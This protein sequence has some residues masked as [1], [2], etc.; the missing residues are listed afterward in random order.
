MLG[1]PN[2]A[3]LSDAAVAGTRR[4]ASN[5]QVLAICATE[6]HRT[7]SSS[8]G[9]FGRRRVV[10]E[11]LRGV[12]LDVPQ[13][14]LFGLLGPN[15]AG[16][17]TLIKILSTVLL[18]T[19]GSVRVFDHDITRDTGSVRRI[20]GLVFGGDRGVYGTL[21]GRDTLRFWADLY[22]LEPAY[23]RRR[24]EEVLQ[25]VGLAGRAEERVET[26]S[27][28]MKQR[29]HL[30]RG[31]LH[32][33]DLLLLDEPTIGLDPVAALQVREIVRDL[34]RQGMTILLTTHYM[35]EAESLCGRVAFI[36]E[37]QIVSVGSPKALTQ[38]ADAKVVLELTVTH[39]AAEALRGVLVDREITV[40]ESPPSSPLVTLHISA[41]R[42][43]LSELLGIVAAYQPVT[44]RTVEPSLED[45]YLRLLGDRGMRI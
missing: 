5:T 39:L 2:P 14:E 8:A 31:I 28:G 19:A 44:L 24:V 13:G 18:P 26:Y 4:G 17:T 32:H 41:P 45:V 16:K 38:A 40:T 3:D 20:L 15:G 6:L 43:A 9:L 12:S 22:H 1:P 30:A 25:L 10:R 7:Y 36:N 29:L 21:N 11:A 37:G 27:R 42:D 34:H 33:P 23:A 35:G